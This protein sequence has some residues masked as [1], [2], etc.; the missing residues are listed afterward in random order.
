MSNTFSR[1]P[2]P[3]IRYAGD[4][5]RTTFDL[6]FPVLA[7]DDLLA[8]IDDEPATGFAITGLGDSTGTITF[9]AP[10]A[11][12]TTITLLRRTEGIRETEFVDGGPFRAATINAE[13]DRVMMLIQENREEHNRALRGRAFEG[14][15]DFCLPPVAQRANRLL[16]F[17]SSGQPMVFGQTQLPISGDASGQLVT[18]TGATTA[19]ALGEHLAAVVNVRDFGAIGDGVSDDTAAFQ[20]ALAAAQARSGVAY[21]PAS[22]N[23]YVI[24]VGLALDGVS[25]V[26]DGPGSVLK[27]A[28]ASGFA[29]RLTGEAPRA[30]GLRLLGPG[31]NA[32]PQSAEEVDL[33]GVALDGLQIA[34]NAR[35][36]MLQRIEVAA[37]HTGLAIEG[38][39][40]AILDCAFAF[41]VNGS[42]VR[43]GAAGSIHLAR[44]K[45]H[46]CTHG[47]RTEPGALFDRATVSG[48]EASLCGRAIELLAPADG[49][50][51]VAISDLQLL[52]NLDV[53][54]SIGPRHTAAVRGCHIDAA[55]KRSGVGIEV[56]AAGETELAPSL[57]IENTRADVTEVN[58]V[59]LV[60][61]TNLD[62][63]QPG[64]L[65]VLASDADD[66]DDLWT[67]HKAARAAVVHEVVS[68]TTG[69]AEIALA[70]AANRPLLQLG[71]II[72]VVGRA[73]T[74]TVDG[75][76]AGAPAATFTWL[77]ADDHSRVLAA[78]N[79]MSADQIDMLG[80]NADLRYVP[81]R[82]G[83]PIAI[84]GVQLQQGAVNG[85]LT[86]LVTFEIAQDT[87]VSFKPDSTVGMVHVFGHAAG[88][89]PSAAIFTYR[90]DGFA[91][92]QLL[93][94]ADHDPDPPTVELTAGTALTGT[95]G[96]SDVFTV[97]AHT[98][99]KIYM[100]NRMAGSPRT[101]SA[102]VIGAPL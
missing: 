34:A 36:A 37:C 60:G 49:Q 85:V 61:G 27:L 51:V 45:F 98:D 77:R 55:G 76:G 93:A 7:G 15:L 67:T 64:D 32:W 59:M 1:D 43:T 80:S 23:P 17:D 100:E 78:H 90:A 94:R 28:L 81:G 87:A 70:S 20:A 88:G 46:A 99:G 74:A 73:G 10:P 68:Q 19:R 40:G 84:S 82:A 35:D 16:G 86:Q 12:G 71:D 4:G 9:A 6:P 57:T 25:L 26:G 69:E 79:P 91:Y 92:T 47:I 89:D 5:A 54:I 42:E 63:L 52:G 13:L 38:P 3:R 24:G 48:G 65:I 30:A 31:S 2:Q 101:V 44:T 29:L 66:I 11:A 56:L 97:S 53:D 18:S 39:A 22:P 72:R 41:C 96:N 62:L 21:V 83:E 102:F 33:D 75:V 8:F 50:R 14:D 95:T 58:H